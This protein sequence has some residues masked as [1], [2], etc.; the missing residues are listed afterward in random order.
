[1][2]IAIIGYGKMGRE[3]A[4]KAESQGIGVASVIDPTEPGA[5]YKAIDSQ[6]LKGADVAVDF[7]SPRSAIQNIRKVSSL[8]KNIVVGTTGWYDREEEARKM[9]GKAGTGLI[10][11]PNF[12]I[13]VNLFFKIVRNASSLIDK[14]PMYDVFVSEWHHNQKE[15][16][17]SGTA[18]M[19][20][21]IITREVRRKKKVVSGSP[22]RK[23]LPEELDIASIRSG[24]MPGLHTV[25][26]DSESDT[27]ELTHTARSR[28]GFATGALLAAKWI[29]GKKGFYTME[30]LMSAILEG[31]TN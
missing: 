25:G 8:G 18:K 30:D 2:K 6:S 5:Q 29:N 9:I 14:A 23:L 3:I 17:P 19:L 15:D 16:S 10:Y 26:F 28:E 24:S 22:S 12:S 20:G 31:K 7:S 1:M 27:I 13:G 4:R 21:E 11:G